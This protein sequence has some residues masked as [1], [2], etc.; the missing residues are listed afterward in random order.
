MTKTAFSIELDIEGLEV[1]EVKLHR[2][3]HYEIRVKSTLE[4]GTCHLC[5]APITKP[6]F[7]PREKRIR[8][9]PILGRETYLIVK[10]PRCKSL[11]CYEKPTT[12]GQVPWHERRSPNTIPFEKHIILGLIGSTVEEVSLRERIG[13]EAVMGIIRR[14]VQSKVDWESISSLEQIGLDEISLKKGHKDFV[15]IVSA[16][17][18]GRVQLLAVLKDR[19]KNTVKDFLRTLPDKLKKTVKSV[20]SDIYEGF[21]NAAKEVFGKRTKIVIDRFHVAKQY[22]KGLDTLRIQEL[23]R[24]IEPLTEEEY[25]ELKGAMWVLRSRQKDLTV[26]NKALLK[27]L[28]GHSPSLEMAYQLQNERTQDF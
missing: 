27:L 21:I 14:H 17:L 11:D 5:G 25:A 22:R 16:Y 10:L 20:C 2:K 7:I 18:E 9:L 1:E 13:Y 15:T 3:G 23:K 12:T 19:K 4:G 6:H 8:H 28:F 24:L 26:E